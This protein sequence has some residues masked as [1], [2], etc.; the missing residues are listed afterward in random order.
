MNHPH[1]WPLVAAYLDNALDPDARALFEEH[2]LNC[3]ECRR[4]LAVSRSVKSAL[5][6]SLRHP[7]PTALRAKLERRMGKPA[8]RGVV[9]R[10]LRNP[11]AWIPASAAATALLAAGLWWNRAKPSAEETLALGPLLT[12]HSRY[13][14]EQI[15]PTSDLY[16][17]DFSA[18]LARY[19]EDQ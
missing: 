10:I 2:S 11:F 18:R 3:P 16:N 19:D 1:P 13:S 9:G 17:T 5:S 12:A 7:M 6:R 15:A 4:E 14:S 8:L